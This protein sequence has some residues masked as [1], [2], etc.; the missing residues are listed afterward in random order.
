MVKERYIFQME[1][2]MLENGKRGKLS[3]YTYL[4]QM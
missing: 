1:V 3:R 2:N 4:R